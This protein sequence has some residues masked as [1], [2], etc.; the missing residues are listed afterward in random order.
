[1]AVLGHHTV[2]SEDASDLIVRTQD[3]N[4]LDVDLGPYSRY[5]CLSWHMQ[6]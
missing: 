4:C 6:Y 5:D 2:R 3:S 1:M